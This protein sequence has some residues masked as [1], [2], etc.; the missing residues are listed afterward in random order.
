MNEVSWLFKKGCCVLIPGLLFGC[1]ARHF[2]AS[3][4]SNGLTHRQVP[5]PPDFKIGDSVLWVGIEP[6]L[7]RDQKDGFAPPDLLLKSSGQ[8]LSLK[9]AQGVIHQAE[10]ISLAWRKVVL[11][12]PK[13]F[14]RQVSGPFASFESANRFALKLRQL[15]IQ[16]VVAH[17]QDWEV[18]FPLG[19][20]LPEG[21]S[22][23]EWTEI[24][25]EKV[26]P[27]LKGL[28][29]EIPLE[30]PLDIEAPDGLRLKGGIYQGPFR[31]QTDAYGSWTLVELV[32]LERYLNGVVPYEIG[33]GSPPTALAAQ[34]VLAR[35][36]ALAN[37]HRF[38]V[39]GYHLCSN[40]QCQVYKDPL[41]VSPEVRQAIRSTA[42]KVL[43]WN[44]QPIHAVYHASN[45]GV[46]AIGTEA[47]SMEPVPY[48][49]AQLDG[50]AEFR[51]R[52][53]LPINKSFLLKSLLDSGEEAYG[54]RHPRFRWTRVISAQELKSALY[55]P[56]NSLFIPDQ[57][58]VLER[59]ISGRVLS[60]EISAE[61]NHPP[62]VLRLDGIRRTLPKLPSTLF[63]VNQLGKG[64]WQF[65][66]GGFGHGAGLSQ[67]GA[68][69]LA[70]KGWTLEKIF[71]HYYPG[72]MY[73]SL[74]DFWKAP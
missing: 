55:S 64:I 18:W 70:N 35:T 28:H 2:V 44:N 22:A 13:R 67:A 63:V 52:F 12:E 61:G 74:P 48:L 32:P 29:G 65:Y 24:S 69:D 51:E 5:K 56:K 34:A 7:G 6:Y 30:G 73:G 49:K 31:L 42:G 17:P 27:F 53:R 58:T 38:S 11:R 33:A 43:T 14:S 72:T 20:K 9:D 15:G 59:G 50:P 26:Q 3:E 54:N 57:V 62:I 41:Q 45:G 60:L 47:W 4:A 71:Q 36:W 23:L 39:D 37:S 66:G 8:P 19:V 40:T 16:A 46:M 10:E 1:H 21:M 25:T 68:I